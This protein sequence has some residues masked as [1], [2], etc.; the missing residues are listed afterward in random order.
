MLFILWLALALPLLRFNLSVWSDEA[1]SVWFGRW[2][3][4][5][6]FTRLCDPHPVGYYV[7]LKAWLSLGEQE[8]WLRWPSL[9]AA[10]LAV[11]LTYRLAREM[12][13]GERTAVLAALL[14][15][16]SPLQL[17]YAAEARMYTLAA[18]LAL[19]A[20]LAGWRLL[21]AL[22]ESHLTSG[23]QITLGI[24][25]TALAML[26]LGADYTAVLP[27][28]ALQ[29]LWLANGLHRPKQWLLWQI[30]AL[31]GAY[32]LWVNAAHRTAVATSFQAFTLAVQLNHFGFDITPAQTTGL[33]RLAMIGL[34][35]AGVLA[36]WLWQR[37][38]R[39]R[40]WPLLWWLV[41]AA[42]VGLTLFMAVPRLYSLKRQW[43]A[44]LPLLAL[45]TAYALSHLPRRISVLVL[46]LTV[47]LAVVV[48]P[49]PQRESWRPIMAELAAQTQGAPV[50][51]DE[52]SVTP[53]AYYDRRLRSQG[54]P[55]LNWSPLLSRDLPRLPEPQ[56]APGHD[57]WLILSEGPYRHFGELMPADFFAQYELLG[58]NDTDGVAL[59]HYRRRLTPL[60]RPPTLPPPSR[61]TL[62]S[63]ES[64]FPLDVCP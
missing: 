58:R 64:A 15:A 17:W 14:L 32:L 61:E 62:W 47:A 5:Q 56:P 34:A 28:F 9:A 30:L 20:V 19:L 52:W 4:S 49:M 26:A 12:R 45:A 57:L 54:R 25:Y 31:A 44:L 46:A 11:A 50:W 40:H 18:A 53:V 29:M 38:S 23:R 27:W 36:A 8:W 33:L 35:A 16:I 43:V 1:T 22:A 37:W 10:V 2:P 21:R 48:L 24:S 51:V 59:L 3:L 13:L 39:L 42:W 63:L 41:S 6:L 55:G 60:S 7:A